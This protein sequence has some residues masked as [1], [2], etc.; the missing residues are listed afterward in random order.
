MNHIKNQGC[1][2]KAFS[3]LELLVALAIIGILIG[4]LLPAVQKVREAAARMKSKNNIKQM[5]LALHSYGTANDMYPMM[6][7]PR[8]TNLHWRLLP[9]LDG[10]QAILDEWSKSSSSL[11]GVKTYVSPSD[12]TF[13][14]D[15]YS[16]KNLSSYPANYQAFK[17]LPRPGRSYPD[18][19][20]QT[21]CFGEHYSLCQD[22]LFF[23]TV[24]NFGPAIRQAT[25]ADSRGP[26]QTSGNFQFFDVVPVT[27]GFP[28]Q[29]K[30]S[31]PGLTFQVRPKIEECNPLI[32]QTPHVAGMN[33]SMMDGS[34]HT[35]SPTIDESLFWSLVTPDGGEVV[36]D[37][38]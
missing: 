32:P 30:S 29:T 14:W 16:F 8:L 33:C 2:R 15:D 19:S 20:T 18:G 23:Y 31:E 21:I 5:S 11:I 6:D 27:T 38:D 25:F 10:G 22:T 7:N 9:Y 36:S 17:G 4:L 1:D 28:P 26:H 3:L 34:V 37:W 35:L 13:H 12:P 24:A